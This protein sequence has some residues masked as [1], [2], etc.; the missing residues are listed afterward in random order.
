MALSGVS[1]PRSTYDPE[2]PGAQTRR[3]VNSICDHLVGLNEDQ[4]QICLSHPYAMPSVSYGARDGIIEC[5]W[6][7]KFERWNC[8]M[9]RTE[10][11]SREDVFDNIFNMGM[12]SIFITNG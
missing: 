6:Q 12:S 8:S 10:N 7:F 4:K 2:L 9:R 11:Q 5:Q 3:S 1:A